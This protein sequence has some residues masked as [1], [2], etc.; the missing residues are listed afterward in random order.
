MCAPSAGSR[1]SQR[2]TG[3]SAQVDGLQSDQATCLCKAIVAK[4]AVVL[5]PLR[6]ALHACPP[7]LAPQPTASRC[8]LDRGQSHSAGNTHEHIRIMVASH[9]MVVCLAGCSAAPPAQSAGSG[10]RD[11]SSTSSTPAAA[12]AKWATCPICTP[13]TRM[14]A[15]L[16][17]IWN[18]PNTCSGQWGRQ[19]V[20]GLAG[21]DGKAGSACS[22]ELLQRRCAANPCQQQA[23]AIFAA[24][25][26]APA[27]LQTGPG[28]QTPG[29]A[30]VR[31]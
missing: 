3:G 22:L 31:A 29:G 27:A 12:P 4:L 20:A 2:H 28:S 8:L 6:H 11:R 10:S 14:P 5:C 9:Q 7:A 30:S 19:A 15:L 16:A 1:E 25:H 21:R 24:G 13:P 17:T 23:L 18:S 26:D